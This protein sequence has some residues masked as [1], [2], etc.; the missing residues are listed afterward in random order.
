MFFE[1]PDTFPSDFLWGGA[2]ASNQADGLIGKFNKG[3]S[4]ADYHPYE[5]KQ[6]RDDRKEDAT[7]KNSLASLVIDGKKYYPKQKGI[8]FSEY[9]KKD[10]ALMQE[11]GLKA[12]RTSFDWS[13]IFPNGDDKEPNEQGLKYY[14]ALLDEI[15][16]CGMEPIM[17]ISH[18]EMPIN[19]V[20]TYGGWS[21][22]ALIHFY[23]DFCKVLF[24]RYHTKVNYWITF[25]QI[26]LLTFNSLGIL[27]DD[28]QATY[29]AVHNQL[30]ASAKAKEIARSYS[31]QL[32]VGTMLSDKVAHPAS[33]KP[34]DVLFSLKKNQL[35]FF[36]SDVQLR[37]V[38][39]GY[40]KRMLVENDI[41]L[42]IEAEDLALLKN[43]TLD[44]L[45]FSY[46]YTKINDSS[47]D[48]LFSATR[49]INPHLKKSEWGWEIDPIGLRTALNTYADRYP[50]VP[51]LI[52]ENGFGAK[53]Q[54]V[55][56]EIQDQYRIDYLN[57]HFYQMREAIKDGVP[58]LGYLVW[59]PIDIISCSSAEM[60]KR[61]GMI[62]V[63]LDNEGKGS[64]ERIRKQSFYWYQKIIKG[65]GD[66][67]IN[68]F[69]KNNRT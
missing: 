5:Y 56:G 42:L 20:K 65:N 48:E 47:Q 8:K 34:A 33:S 22:R 59:T 50:G 19:L 21:N 63:D 14:D 12:F 27:S 24:K 55:D 53:D 39:P 52:T 25:N 3:L 10:L 11:M 62:Y 4:I 61:Y 64:L 45:S 43:N 46:Y 54:L 41:H 18:Y 16:A 38:Y 68:N 36:F 9:F 13:L 29:Q 69:S 28:L 60:S 67:L 58:L 6:K 26:N 7:I 2:I 30:V 31:E 35:Q 44:F 57:D 51:L 49:S 23:V 32:L 1:L 40:M 66:H 15:I 37:G 17:S